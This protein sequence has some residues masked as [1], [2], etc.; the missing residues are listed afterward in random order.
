MNYKNA[1]GYLDITKKIGGRNTN[2]GFN[3]LLLDDKHIANRYV[4][5]GLTKRY[6]DLLVG[7]MTREWFKIKEDTDDK[8]LNY[9]QSINA[10][11]EV[12]KALRGA[13]LFGGAL[14]FLVIEDGKLPNEP[15]D[16]N[17]IKSI[18]KLKY[19]S[20]SKITVDE[21]NYYS[22][23]TAANFDEPEFFTLQQKNGTNFVVHESRCLI[24]HGDYYPA[25]E[26]DSGN[27]LG[28]FWG[29]SALQSVWESFENLSLAFE[30][31]LKMLSKANRDV[32]KIDGLFSLLS[33]DEG[34]KQLEARAA[35]HD[36]SSSVST[37][38]I[39]DTQ[40][41]F[42]NLDLKLSGLADVYSKAEQYVVALIG[43]PMVIFF[44]TSAKG[45]NAS[46][47]N[48]IKTYYDKIQAR[49][50]EDLLSLLNKLVSYVKNI[51]ELK[52]TEE[53]ATIEFNS[54]WVMNEKELIETRSLQAKT[55]EIYINNQ[56]VD[57]EEVR[58]SRFG[59]GIYSYETKIEGEV[60]IPID[61]KEK[62]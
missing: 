25:D 7:D 3:L 16:T 17:N 9:L 1:D 21:G 51:K 41:E 36:L 54:L 60:D 38:T 57:S 14:L 61:D 19:Y 29:V 18:K 4:G 34:K 2:R 53:E 48:D 49:Q 13:K 6:I 26:I 58:S 12:K 24:F 37:T 28:G 15:V 5:D 62:K 39:I 8:I 50:Q 43:V 35:L 31:M 42:I 47:E 44:G 55:D 56:I 23:M 30:A 40:E 27:E 45:L 52:Y 10:K 33:N 20:K 59:G 32:L 11:A 22:D 46:S